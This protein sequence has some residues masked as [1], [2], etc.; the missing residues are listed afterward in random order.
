MKSQT[1]L[2]NQVEEGRLLVDGGAMTFLSLEAGR[3]WGRELIRSGLMK[4]TVYPKYV[5]K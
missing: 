4:L 1:S 3:G 2:W 5:D